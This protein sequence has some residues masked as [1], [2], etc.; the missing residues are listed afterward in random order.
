MVAGRKAYT[1]LAT[2]EL[3]AF[4]YLA[5]YD[6]DTGVW[7]P[8]RSMPP[9]SA[10]MAAFGGRIYAFGERTVVYDPEADQWTEAASMGI[11]RSEAAPV[12]VGD[13]I[14]L[15]GGHGSRDDGIL[16]DITPDILRFDPRRNQ[17]REGP[18]LPWQ[19][20]GSAA[21]EV[22]GRLFVIGGI[23]PGPVW[24]ADQSVFEYVPE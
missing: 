15:I 23:R 4:S 19:R 21:I 11:P 7:T 5:E 10:Q 9:A 16:G 24:S 18:A 22:K 3:R 20:W 14:W 2:G 12:A 8:R 1:M 17:W 6:L 13:E